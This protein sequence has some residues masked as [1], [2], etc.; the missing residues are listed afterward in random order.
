MPAT[1]VGGPLSNLDAVRVWPI[2]DQVVPCFGVS[3]CFGECSLHRDDDI[4]REAPHACPE[5]QT[6][7]RRR[8]ARAAKVEGGDPILEEVVE[9]FVVI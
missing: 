4:G 1:A 7:A 5:S 8:Q 9:T 6:R 3:A 2:N